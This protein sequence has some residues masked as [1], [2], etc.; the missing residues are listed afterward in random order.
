MNRYSKYFLQNILWLDDGF[1]QYYL[2]EATWGQNEILDVESV[3][4]NWTEEAEQ[5]LHQCASYDPVT[6]LR[7]LRVF[8]ADDCQDYFDVHKMSDKRV[9]HAAARYLSMNAH[10]L[11]IEPRMGWAVQVNEETAE[12]VQPISVEPEPDIS[13][14]FTELQ[15]DLNAMVAE[16]QQKYNAYEAKMANM[17]EA[18]KA[19]FYSEN[20]GGAV[21]DS[22]IGDTVDLVG[23]A[24]KGFPNFFKGYLKTLWKVAQ[25]P[26]KMAKTIARAVAAG[27][28]NPIKEEIDKIVEPVARTYH[29]AAEY[30][31]MLTILFS[32]PVTHDMLYKFAD[33]YWQATHP[34]ERTKMGASAVTDIVVTI[35]LAIISAGVGAVANIAAK[36]TRLVKVAKLLKKIAA[37]LKKTSPGTKILDRG[38]GGANKAKNA[39][40]TPTTTQKGVPEVKQPKPTEKVD[41]KKKKEYGNNDS[42]VGPKTTRTAEDGYHART[43]PEITQSVLDKID[44]SRFSPDTRFGKAF[45][46]ADKGDV[47]VAEIAH[48]G[49]TPTH[50]I[51]YKLDLSKAKVLDLTDPAVVKKW[52]SPGG[53]NY[54]KTQAIAKKAQEAGFDAIRFPSQRAGGNN[55]AIFDKFDEILSPQMV[56]PVK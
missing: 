23:T 44:P 28:M 53:N 16:Q 4:F 29:Q 52:G 42:G 46:I 21:Y 37:V 56:T 35:I 49:A 51:R 25:T 5:W 9:L 7:H 6:T 12:P 34:I 31:S 14:L 11:V 36:S 50:M 10:T 19:L 2:Q 48:H 1:C 55:I 24:I 41:N 27:N 39:N 40:K 8:L 43:S 47:A 38:K 17:N 18:E 33:Q 22:A 26:N 13:H 32:E 45:Y 15:R 30:K 3:V 20:A 54:A